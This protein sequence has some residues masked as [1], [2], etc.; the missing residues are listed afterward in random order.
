MLQFSKGFGGLT[1]V[2][3]YN[4]SWLLMLLILSVERRPQ[5]PFCTVGTRPIFDLE[6]PM[7]GLDT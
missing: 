1:T 7:P 4:R 2:R 6:P 3:M 5:R